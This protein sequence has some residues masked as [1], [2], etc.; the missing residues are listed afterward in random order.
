MHP[1]N[2]CLTS[3]EL[4]H[5]SFLGLLGPLLLLSLSLSSLRYSIL[6]YGLTRSVERNNYDR[7]YSV[8]T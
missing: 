5:L 1:R 3:L 2:Q 6:F 7:T 4:M 8:R